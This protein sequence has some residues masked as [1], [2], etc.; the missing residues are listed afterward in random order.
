M[1][2]AYRKKEPPLRGGQ[3]V[4]TISKMEKT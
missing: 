2:A 1:E 4:S 3:V